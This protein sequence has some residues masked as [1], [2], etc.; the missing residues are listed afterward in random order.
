MNLLSIIDAVH[1]S[2]T[3]SNNLCR[4]I[5]EGCER[6]AVDGYK[7]S[8]APLPIADLV[9]LDSDLESGVT[10]HG[11]PFS[12]FQHPDPS[13]LPKHIKLSPRAC[14]STLMPTRCFVHSEYALASHGRRPGFVEWR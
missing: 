10:Q 5:M 14:C 2:I 11:E 3:L 12:E 9:L 7:K 6:I 1:G 4:E 13:R 8:R